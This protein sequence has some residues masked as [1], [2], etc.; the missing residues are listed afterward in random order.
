VAV[1][2]S[3]STS[4]A[5]EAEE[6]QAD[7]VVDASGRGSRSSRWLAEI[8]YTV[9]P[10]RVVDGGFAYTT[11][12]LKECGVLNGTDRAIYEVG[13]MST[14]GRSGVF[15]SI[16]HDQG[17]LL[18]CSRRDDG[19]P[20]DHA[21]FIAAIRSLENPALTKL[22]ALVDPAGPLYRFVHLPNRRRS[23]HRMRYWPAGFLVLGDALCVLNPIYGQGMTVAALQA[24][25]LRRLGPSLRQRPDRTR[26]VQRLLARRTWLAWLVSSSQDSRWTQSPPM[27]SSAIGWLLNRTVDRSTVSPHVHLAFL[28]TMH[29]VA[30]GALLHPRPLAALLRP[31]LDH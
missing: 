20:N 9:P 30:P 17:Q 29:L 13:Q 26:A 11:A 19:L 15:V 1:L 8:G 22:S 31:S 28:K 4:V 6:I 10:D 25:T 24:E 16:E 27:Y 7:L 3:S 18:V 2:S 21:D 5:A 23:F 14:F 12:W